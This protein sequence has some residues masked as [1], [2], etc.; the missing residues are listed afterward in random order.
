[1]HICKFKFYKYHD[2]LHI[3]NTFYLIFLIF[4]IAVNDRRSSKKKL[5]M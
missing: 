1:M 2:D 3:E 4:K 5:F